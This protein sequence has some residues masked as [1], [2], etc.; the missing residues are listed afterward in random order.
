MVP[1]E[2]ASIVVA[3]SPIPGVLDQMQHWV[4]VLDT[5]DKDADEQIFIYFVENGKSEEIADILV[6]LYGGEASNRSGEDRN[7]RRKSRDSSSKWSSASGQ[8][9]DSSSGTGTGSQQQLQQIK[10]QRHRRQGQDKQLYW[11]TIL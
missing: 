8:R 9:R 4:D 10:S 2:R 5:I 6:Q 3:V 11:K 7:A 1:V